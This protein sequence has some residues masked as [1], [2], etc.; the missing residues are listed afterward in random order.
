VGFVAAADFLSTR[1]ATLGLSA[2]IGTIAVWG[3]LALFILW[4]YPTYSR[5][6]AFTEKRANA[7][8][9]QRRTDRLA[10]IDWIEASTNSTDIFLCDDRTALFAVGPAGRYVL[11]APRIYSNPYTDWELRER[12]R[13]RLLTFLQEGQEER[14][15]EYATRNRI[16]YAIFEEEREQ[17]DH[18][19]NRKI[20]NRLACLRPV[21]Q[22]GWITIYEVE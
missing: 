12:R 21:F 17:P 1:L 20:L 10:A 9:W 15:R 13:K 14:F 8:A 16:R 11:A 18:P 7:L 19:L 5:R 3:S 4:L 6:T 22:R 2:R